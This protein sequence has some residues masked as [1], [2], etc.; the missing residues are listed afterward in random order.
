MD[1]K[2]R[3]LT[4]REKRLLQ[5]YA[6]EVMEEIAKRAPQIFAEAPSAGGATSA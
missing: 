3:Q 2:P 4:E 5:E 1:L 6:N